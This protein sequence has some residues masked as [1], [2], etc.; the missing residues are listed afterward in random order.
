MDQPAGIGG[1]NAINI[2]NG[3]LQLDIRS[4]KDTIGNEK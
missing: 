3:Y 4:P 1:Y 2:K